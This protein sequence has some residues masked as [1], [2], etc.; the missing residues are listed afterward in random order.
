MFKS[1]L[2]F[3]LCSTSG[4]AVL[5]QFGISDVN[6]FLHMVILIIMTFVILLLAVCVLQLR[7]SLSLILEGLKNWLYSCT[8]KRKWVKILPSVHYNCVLII[9]Y[10]CNLSYAKSNFKD[11]WKLKKELFHLVVLEYVRE[12]WLQKAG[13]M[14]SNRNWI[15]VSWRREL[16]PWETPVES[17][18]QKDGFKTMERRQ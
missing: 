12:V 10:V 14:R 8:K 2:F 17:K 13:W 11:I 18:R 3:H 5:S 6:P 15:C 7:V 9:L 1:N 16:E 4:Y